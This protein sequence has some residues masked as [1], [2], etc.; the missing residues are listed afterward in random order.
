MYVIFSPTRSSH[1]AY[2]EG[3]ITVIPDMMMQN[4]SERYPIMLKQ[5]FFGIVYSVVIGGIIHLGFNFCGFFNITFDN[6]TDLVLIFVCYAL[7]PIDAMFTFMN[8]I[9]HEPLV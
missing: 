7:G 5:L 4:K 2:F 9:F 1:N 8:V 6:I 3:V